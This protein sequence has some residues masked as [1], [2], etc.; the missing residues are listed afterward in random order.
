[1]CI[2]YWR[3]EI[4]SFPFQTSHPLNQIGG[5]KY[6]WTWLSIHMLVTS[7]TSEKKL[8]AIKIFSQA[9]VKCDFG[10]INMKTCEKG[11]NTPEKKGDLY[12]SIKP[13]ERLF[14]IHLGMGTNFFVP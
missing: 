4:I 10:I 3:H 7:N 12:E 5:A 13:R 1:M 2:D 6:L 8:T 9:H 11:G 14:D